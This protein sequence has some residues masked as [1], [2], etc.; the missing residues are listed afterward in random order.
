MLYGATMKAPVNNIDDLMREWSGDSKIDQTEPG[1]ELLRISSLHSKYLNIMTHH[2]IAVKKLMIDYNK[3]K[4]LKFEYYN[5]D[6]NNPEDLEKY[7]LQPM[8]KRILRSDI[9]IHLDSD[10]DLNSILIKKVLN[11]EIVDFCTSVLKE[12]NS[13]TYQIR[14][15]I[16][17]V[18]FTSGG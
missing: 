5:G 16:D 17:Y 11:Q 14:G 4:K 9:Q 7:N 13:R 10:P 8:V 3:S 6:L 2:N 15:Y 12:L 1:N 18:K